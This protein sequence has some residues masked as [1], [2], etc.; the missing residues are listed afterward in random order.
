MGRSLLSDTA[1]ERHLG[2]GNIIID[3]FDERNLGNGS[4]DVSLGEWYFREQDPKGGFITYNP[5]SQKD[6]ERVWGKPQ[7][8]EPACKWMEETGVRELEG[9][10][11]D[12]LVIWIRPQETLLCHTCEFIGGTGGIVTTMMKARSSMG[13]NF[14]TVCKCAGWGDIG[15]INRWTME[16]TNSSRY[17]LI[18]LVV[19]R[20]LAQIA[21]FEVEPITQANYGKGSKYQAADTIEEIKAS[22][23]PDMLIPHMFADREAKAANEKAIERRIAIST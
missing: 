19:N 18:P 21:F 3:P 7:K 6:V 22:W 16:I 13:R 2:L 20:R 10:L 11:P 15:Y 17:Y 8:A 4:Y 14:I 23:G 5:Y 12:E 9:I 1:S